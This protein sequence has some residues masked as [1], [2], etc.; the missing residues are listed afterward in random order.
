MKTNQKLQIIF[1][2]LIV[3]LLIVVLFVKT[4]CKSGYYSEDGKGSIISPCTKCPSSINEAE[5][6]PVYGLVSCGLQVIDD[7]IDRV[8]D[9]IPEDVQDQVGDIQDQVGDI[10]DQV[11]GIIDIIR[12]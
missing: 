5:D 3:V 4:D 6:T 11:G 2:V 8:E 1:A 10:Q 7:V 9:M 12:P